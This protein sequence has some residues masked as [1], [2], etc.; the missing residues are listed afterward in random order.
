MVYTYVRI[1]L[2]VLQYNIDN[3]KYMSVIY[4]SILFV[5]YLV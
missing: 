4:I 3:N 5:C 1:G 2:Q